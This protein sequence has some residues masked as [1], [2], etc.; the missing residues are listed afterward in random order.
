IPTLDDGKTA[1]DYMSNLLEKGIP[2]V[3]C[4]KGSLSN[5]FPELKKWKDNIGYSATVGGGTRM[6]KY[7]EERISHETKEIHAVV[8]GTLN[9]VLD[10]VSRNRSFGEVIEEA[11]KLG[12]TEP[13]VENPL[14]IINKE[15]TEDIPMKTSILFNIYSDILG[16]G[17]QVKAKDIEINKIG[18][19]ELKKLIKEANRRRYI[20]S[21]T[22]EDNDE[23]VIG[24]FKYKKGDLFIS[25]GFKD[26][27]E[28]P[29]FSELVPG[30]V[31]NSILIC[32]GEYNQ[33]GKYK[34]TGPGAGAGPTV[35]AMIKDALKLEKRNNN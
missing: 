32:E 12:Y 35:S 20:I 17:E 26:I 1:F 22:K 9:F 13:G 30:G 27:S 10:G 25:G 18:E 31:N 14:D 3:T 16:F 21:I 29:L 7:L 34:L 2:V 15:S 24:G 19:S 8:N 4:E 28:N 11:K 33:Y 5:Y 6:L 23:D